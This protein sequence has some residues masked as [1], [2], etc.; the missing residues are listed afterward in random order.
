MIC[1]KPT[2]YPYKKNHIDYLEI[3]CIVALP[4]QQNEVQTMYERTKKEQI[5]NAVIIV[6]V[7]A[8]SFLPFI[9]G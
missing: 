2:L 4:T 8:V 6:I 1:H 5:E 7:F 3:E 9:I